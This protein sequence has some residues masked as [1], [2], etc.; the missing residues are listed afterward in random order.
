MQ[1]NWTV[2]YSFSLY[3]VFVLLP[4]VPAVLIFWL[5]PD[6]KV[7][8][9]GPLE[10]LT[11]NAT[12]AFAAYI[13]TGLLGFFIVRQIEVQIN[14]TRDYPVRGIVVGLGPTEAIYSDRFYSR[15]FSDPQAINQTHQ[16]QFVVVFD[17]PVVTK[18]KV[19]VDYFDSPPSGFGSKPV[20]KELVIELAP[21]RPLQ[22]FKLL[23]DG[24]NLQV[25]SEE[26]GNARNQASQEF[27]IAR[28]EEQ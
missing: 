11:I 14:Y 5:F 27:E 8:V 24:G 21:N 4:L 7:A 6:E 9:T 12:G 15:S 13:I 25:V 2:V 18:E 28:G 16:F 10:G 23:R 17:H 19:N 3:V 26:Q 22:Y 1:T 20:P